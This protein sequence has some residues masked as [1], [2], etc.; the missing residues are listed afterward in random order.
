MNSLDLGRRAGCG[1]GRMY[2]SCSEIPSSLQN[3]LISNRKIE[4]SSLKLSRKQSSKYHQD[5]SNSNS[6]PYAKHEMC[7][8]PRF[9]FL[10]SVRCNADRRERELVLM[11]SDRTLQGDN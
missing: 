7:C 10:M 8:L 4:E 2:K 5:V 11:R 3:K 9:V 1:D 6:Y